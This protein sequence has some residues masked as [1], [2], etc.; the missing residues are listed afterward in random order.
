MKFDIVET[1]HQPEYT[2]ENRCGPCTALN[3]V[4]A[5]FFS[6]VLGQI[7]RAAGFSFFTIS[8]TLIYL[9]GYLVPG[10][11]TLTKRYLPSTV[12]RWFGKEPKI[13]TRSGLN[14]ASA[15]STNGS[16][17]PTTEPS[18]K[19]TIDSIE[20]FNVHDYYLTEGILEPC[21]DHDDLCLVDE[22]RMAW[23]D[24]MVKLAA[25]DL[26]ANNV[27]ST[28]GIKINAESCEIQQYEDE[29]SL[30]ADTQTIGR[31]PSQKALIA[32][33]GASRVLDRWSK[34]WDELQPVHKGQILNSL[35]LFLNQCPGT[36]KS[37]NVTQETVE[38]CCS[39]H[40]IVKV[41]CDET[42]ERL[43]ERRSNNFS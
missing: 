25:R 37:V 6:L 7:S 17:K 26:N 18:N 33:I 36:D 10:T 28:L 31:W 14:S 21:D 16:S 24:E 30:V 15:I 41:S 29:W 11:P 3:L 2:G 43:F 12:L 4:M 8:L 42:G 27:V 5:I 20:E 34:S 1:L 38:S 19:K 9:R 13:D 22:F 32:D 40:D 35:R 39:S 23:N